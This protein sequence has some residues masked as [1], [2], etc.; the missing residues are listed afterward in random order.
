MKNPAQTVAAFWL[1]L[2]RQGLTQ[3]ASVLREYMSAEHGSGE[4]TIRSFDNLGPTYYKVSMPELPEVE[5]VCRKLRDEAF[6]QCIRSARILRLG[7]VHP[8]S[9]D[10]VEQSV[11]GRRILAV[12]RRAKNI[13]L[14]LSGDVAIRIHLRMTGNLYAVPDVRFHPPS[15]R[16]YLEFPSHRGILFTDPRALGKL[17]LHTTQEV[18]GILANLGPEPLSNEF[19]AEWFYAEAKRSRLPAKLFLMDQRRIAGLG[20]IYAAEVLFRARIHPGRV[21]SRLSRPRL[22]ALHA[23]VVQV[24]QE[25]VESACHAYSGPGHFGEAESF[26]CV[27]YDREDRP[28]QVCGRKIR[29]IP[30]GGRSTYYCPGCQR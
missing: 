30:Q 19:T 14:R 28:C 23:A 8:Q 7:I 3:T 16:A 10:Q 9:V 11:A 17:H 5:A 12:E 15:T 24:L 2:K 20:N 27:V 21:V 18:E 29:R 13:F 4:G 6:G 26:S 25:A 1:T 22:F